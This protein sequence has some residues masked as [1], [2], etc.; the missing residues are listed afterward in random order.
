[1]ANHNSI[2][3]YTTLYEL[4][5]L[6]IADCYA[7]DTTT[8]TR[9][10]EEIRCR[11]ASEGIGFLT[12]TLPSY[13]KALDR[14]LTSSHVFDPIG[15]TT[16]ARGLPHFCGFLFERV[17]DSIPSD[18]TYV[19]SVKADADIQAIRHLRQLCIYCYKL[20]LTYDKTTTERV[21]TQFIAVDKELPEMEG[22]STD[23]KAILGIARNLATDV[24]GRFDHRDITPKHGPGSVATGEQRE[25]KLTFKRLYKA[26]DVEYPFT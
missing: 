18:G 20:E 9:D 13:A 26:L 11:V 8:T 14:A 24:F 15:L 1:M 25:G 10:I 3:V 23:A 16:D 6:D 21:I 7:V 4:L 22:L 17:F 12:K 2:A 19:L 5:Y